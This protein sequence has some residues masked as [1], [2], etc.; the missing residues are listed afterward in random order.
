MASAGY[1][2]VQYPVLQL[3]HGTS[4]LNPHTSS[5]EALY[6]VT[7]TSFNTNTGFT[8][9]ASNLNPHTPSV[10]ALNSVTPTGFNTSTGFSHGASNFL[11]TSISSQNSGSLSLSNRYAYIP[12][13]LSSPFPSYSEVLSSAASAAYSSFNVP[14]QVGPTYSTHTPAAY[15][16]HPVPLTTTASPAY[17]THSPAATTPSYPG[18]PAEPK[19][20][21][22]TPVHPS[23][24]YANDATS[25]LP[26]R[27]HTTLSHTG[28]FIPSYY[29]PSPHFA[30]SKALSPRRHSA[31]P[32]TPVNHAITSP[33]RHSDFPAASPPGAAPYTP[34]PCLS[35]VAAT[36]LSPRRASCPEMSIAPAAPVQL[37][38][39]PTRRLAA[40]TQPAHPEPQC[41]TPD[42]TAASHAPTPAPAP[43][44]APAAAPSGPL[45]EDALPPPRW[46]STLRQ[47]S[48]VVH[49]VKT[50]ASPPTDP[51][52]S[53]RSPTPDAPDPTSYRSAFANDCSPAQSLPLPLGTSSARR[54][55]S[56][57]PGPASYR[58]AYTYSSRSSEPPSQSLPLAGLSARSPSSDAFDPASHRSTFTCAINSARESL[59]PAGTSP[60]APHPTPSPEPPLPT[61]S[62]SLGSPQAP[63]QSPEYPTTDLRAHAAGPSGPS[64]SPAA[65]AAAPVPTPADHDPAAPPMPTTIMPNG[66]QV[67]SGSQSPAS[68]VPTLQLASLIPPTAPAAT[69]PAPGSISPDNSLP[70]LT[71]ASLQQVSISVD[72]PTRSPTLPIVPELPQTN[73]CEP[74]RPKSDGTLGI[75]R[76]H[77]EYSDASSSGCSKPSTFGGFSPRDSPQDAA[78]DELSPDLKEGDVETLVFD[79][80]TDSEE[81]LTIAIPFKE[82]H[83][84]LGLHDFH[85]VRI[86]GQGQFGKVCVGPGRSCC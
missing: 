86:V 52:W 59:S 75:P 42:S 31:W 36:D 76:A 16:V 14:S 60:P 54:P 71:A 11:S 37:T 67:D 40:L 65:P 2:G 22:S 48:P 55:S 43:A 29:Q 17:N 84:R 33:R 53:A 6:P 20:P 45:P 27:R 44:P 35:K 12:T 28:N 82:T 51:V 70:R 30:H 3:H 23:S 24:V 49:P 47:V 57:V 38:L 18:M 78:A 79:S 34:D 41:D 68:P 5:V 63:N 58:S 46:H 64:T 7:P 83:K 80:Q 32:T 10:E 77:S 81:K 1:N 21:L 66:P 13:T 50:P 62:Q 26:T 9:G 72:A 4:I 73:G 19:H 61:L 56:D 15:R 69:S 74:K 85:L 25:K 39:P 8:H